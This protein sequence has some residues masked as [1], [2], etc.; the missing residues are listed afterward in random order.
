MNTTNILKKQ[1]GKIGADSENIIN[2]MQFNW[3]DKLN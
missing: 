3:I 1:Q 2:L